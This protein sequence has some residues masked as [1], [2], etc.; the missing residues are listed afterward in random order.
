MRS[1]LS[2]CTCKITALSLRM[3]QFIDRSVG[4]YFFGP[5]C[6][7]VCVLRKDIALLVIFMCRFE[8]QVDLPHVPDMIFA[9][10]WLRLMHEHGFGIEFTTLDALKHVGLEEDLVQVADAKAWKEARSV[11]CCH[12]LPIGMLGIY[13]LLFVFLFVCPQNFW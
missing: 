12:H 3:T 5:P 1:F 8:A 4:A 13:R 11:S 7:C 2:W 6:I 10:N 9:E